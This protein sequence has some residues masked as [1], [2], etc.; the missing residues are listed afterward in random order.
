V[1][2]SSRNCDKI[3][4]YRILNLLMYSN[5]IKSNDATYSIVKKGGNRMISFDIFSISKKSKKI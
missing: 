5:K 4:S 3:K 2:T 1:I